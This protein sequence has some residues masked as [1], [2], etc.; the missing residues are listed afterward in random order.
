MRA[1]AMMRGEL[2]ETELPDP[3]PGPGQLLVAPIAA[4]VCGGDLSALQHAD[5][6]LHAS[7]TSGTQLF[8]FDPDRPL[9]FG[10]EFTSHVVAVGDGVTDY[11]EG[12]VLLTLPSV[13]DPAGVARCVGYATEYPGALA[14]RVVVGAWGHVRLPDGVSPL[15]A[16]AVDPLATGLNGVIRSRI[17]PPAGAIV[18]GCGPVGLGSVAGLVERGIHPIV[19][20]DPSPMRRRIA[21]EMGAHLAVDPATDEPVAA[22]R[23]V[24]D[25]GQALYVYEA[26]GKAGVLD[27]L[28]YAVPPFSRVT[29]VGA[30]MT[31]DVIRPIVGIYKN[32]T[33]EFCFGG[34]PGGEPY[35][36]AATLERIA[37]GRIDAARIVTGYA[38]RAGVPEVFEQLRPGDAHDIEHVKILV[39]HD[40]DGPG[41]HAP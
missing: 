23:D 15:L 39:R 17:E 21:V 22:W 3:E 13:V 16:A 32:V 40:L 20:S 38:G 24:A 12:D 31:D 1:V 25:A 7:R 6:F 26:S 14:E 2:F 8:E 4:G 11:A 35:P 29:V 19:A 41:I 9:V 34:A 18:T 28:L 5:D 27:A 36:F 33:I 30:C 10:H 37:D